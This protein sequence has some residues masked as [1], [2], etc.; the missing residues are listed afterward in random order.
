MRA[1]SL[2]PLPVYRFDTAAVR[3][4]AT[5]RPARAVLLNAGAG[6][7]IAP[8]ECGSA[9]V[10]FPPVPCRRIGHDDYYIYWLWGDDD[11]A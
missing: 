9:P 8:G 2:T 10:L 11:D 1:P 7:V 4:G 5:W 3:G 6:G